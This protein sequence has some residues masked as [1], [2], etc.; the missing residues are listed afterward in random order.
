MAH[1][2]WGIASLHDYDSGPIRLARVHRDGAILVGGATRA[3]IAAPGMQRPVAGVTPRRA[4]HAATHAAR[5]DARAAV[6]IETSPRARR[7]HRARGSARPRI[8]ARFVDS[9]EAL[10]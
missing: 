7:V 5:R 1:P 2:L 3:L 9:A 4:R 10:S 8:G 6:A